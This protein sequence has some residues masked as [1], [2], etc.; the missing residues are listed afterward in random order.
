MASVGRIPVS[1]TCQ[2]GDSVDS[3]V[4]WATAPADAAAVAR[5][6]SD[7]AEGV[8]GLVDP[9]LHMINLQNHAIRCIKDTTLSH[10]LFTSFSSN[11]NYDSRY[12]D[13]NR[14]RDRNR[15]ESKEFDPDS[16]SDFD[17]DFDCTDVP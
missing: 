1:L 7:R 12:R 6:V 17:F 11:S 16:D 5:D 4:T 8:S 13:P 2:A 15:R 9:A 3:P 14:D 10:A